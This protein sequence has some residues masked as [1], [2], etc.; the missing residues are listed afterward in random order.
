MS[1]APSIYRCSPGKMVIFNEAT[2]HGSK[3]NTS[4]VARVAL[5]MRYTS[6]DVKF[7]MEKWSDPGRIKTFLVRGVDE[8]H[9]NDAIRGEKP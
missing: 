9:L 5:S 1:R 4:D 3:A 6:P 2:Y 8:Y 7:E